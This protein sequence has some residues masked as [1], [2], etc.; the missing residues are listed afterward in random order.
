VINDSAKVVRQTRRLLGW[1]NPNNPVA[2]FM[3]HEHK[4]DVYDP[5]HDLGKTIAIAIGL[6]VI[7]AAGLALMLTGLA[8]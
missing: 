5:R 3:F 4:L 8:V 6:T 7:L 2:A 1:R